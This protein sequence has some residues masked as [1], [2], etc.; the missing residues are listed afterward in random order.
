MPNYWGGEFGSSGGDREL[1]GPPV[2]THSR[3]Q[4]ELEAE[5]EANSEL[6]KRSERLQ[7]AR[8]SII[9]GNY[10][11]IV[12]E[13]DVSA[14]DFHEASEGIFEVVYNGTVVGYSKEKISKSDHDLRLN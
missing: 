6:E 4:A 10:L 7:V 5:A 8:E 3:N 13:V 11:H 2:E 9:N 12:D 14:C 1:G